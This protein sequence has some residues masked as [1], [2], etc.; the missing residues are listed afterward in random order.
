M[1]TIKQTIGQLSR[2][3]S[4]V[5]VVGGVCLLGVGMVYWECCIALLNRQ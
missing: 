3:V 4:V 1:S 2:P 5:G